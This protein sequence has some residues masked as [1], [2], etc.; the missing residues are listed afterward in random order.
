VQKSARARRPAKQDE[1]MKV[2]HKLV[3]FVLLA[4]ATVFSLWILRAAATAAR[5]KDALTAWADTPRLMVIG[6]ALALLCLLLL[7]VL[8]SLPRRSRRKLLSFDNEG[9]TVSISTDAIC[10][11]IGK[12]AVEFPSVVRLV[13]EVIAG[14]DS[15]DLRVGVR[16][17]AG[18]QIHEVCELLQQRVRDS[19]STGLGISQIGKVEV[20][21]T[22]IVSEHRPQ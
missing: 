10:D 12:L 15:I 13:P 21:V 7:H 4:V 16:M 18:P 8:T 22:D 17:K 14:R 9:G 19:V 3:E 20:S 2:M 11:Y 1:P 6:L 5:W